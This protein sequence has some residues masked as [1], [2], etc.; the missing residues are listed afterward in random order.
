MQHRQSQRAYTA[1]EVMLAIAVL[2]VGAAGV[3]SMQRGSIVG[4]LESRRMDVANA[5]ARTWVE[6]LRRDAT[7]WTGP[8]AY[9]VADTTLPFTNFGVAGGPATVIPGWYQPVIP[10]AYSPVNG[11]DGLSPM[12]DALG[13]DLILTDVANAVYC[14]VIKVDPIVANGN[15]TNPPTTGS[16]APLEMVRETVVVFWPKQLTWASAAPLSCPSFVTGSGKDP[17]FIEAT[18][19]GTYHFIF[20]STPIMKNLL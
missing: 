18:T 20:A 4:D 12:F 16:A 19:P 13:R 1:I 6:R 2:G 8:N 7:A 9:V 15:Y 5:I 3:M 10:A 14:V 11:A 17:V